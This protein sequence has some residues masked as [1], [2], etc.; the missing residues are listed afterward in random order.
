MARVLAVALFRGLVWPWTGL[1]AW[2]GCWVRG[3]VFDAP[4]G[5]TGLC[6]G[7]AGLGSRLGGV[8]GGVLCLCRS[9]GVF[10]SLQI[11]VG[12]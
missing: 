10:R 7:L 5:R 1:W 4:A 11:S 2:L 6:R 9:G 8:W 3:G 12:L